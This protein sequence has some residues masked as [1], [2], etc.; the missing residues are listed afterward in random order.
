MKIFDDYARFSAEWGKVEKALDLL[1]KKLFLI[2]ESHEDFL[3]TIDLMREI[4]SS[5][6][7]YL[8]ALP[9]KLATIERIQ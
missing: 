5:R 6:E 8:N 2:D 3:S 1:Q 7:R 4:I 9:G